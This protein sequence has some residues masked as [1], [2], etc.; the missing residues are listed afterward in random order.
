DQGLRAAQV[1]AS[2]DFNRK[3]VGLYDLY[4]A[5]CQREGVVDFAELLLRT[6]ELLSRNQ[7]LREH[8]QER[9]RHILVDEF[10]DTNDLQYK[11][12][13]LMAGAGNRR[14]NAVFAVGDD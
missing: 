4:D 9:F 1:D 3:M 8:Y 10:Q 6:Y 14:P 2:D 13:K 7:P 11:W 12:L 5:Q